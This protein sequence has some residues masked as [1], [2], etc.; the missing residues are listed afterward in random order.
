[1]RIKKGHEWMTAFRTRYGHFEHCVMPFGLSNAPAA[2]Q[3]MMNSIFHDM[4]D[5][6]VV[7]YLDDILI[8]SDTEEQHEDHLR[9]VLRQLQ[10]NKLMAKREKC[11]F[12]REEIT[13]L[14]YIISNNG[15]RMD[16]KRYR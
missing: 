3:R 6:F 2:F 10:E 5:E 14:G 13:F 8:F 12:F 4:L 11:E 7:I 1:M 9:R 16:E 15:V